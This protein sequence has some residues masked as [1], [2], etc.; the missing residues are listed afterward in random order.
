MFYKIAEILHNHQQFL[1]QLEER[2]KHWHDEQKIG[3]IISQSFAQQPILDTYSEFTNNFN[4]AKNLISK[5]ASKPAFARFLEERAKENKEK[6]SLS[7]LIIQPIQRI[8]RYELL[9]KVRNIL[10]I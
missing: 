9:L 4:K 5:A 7:D 1:D 2:M 3:D 10:Y 8:P 6:L